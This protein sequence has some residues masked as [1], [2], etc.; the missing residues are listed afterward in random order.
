MK[1]KTRG[2]DYLSP[3]AKRTLIARIEE[4]EDELAAIDGK[5]NDDT[6]VMLTPGQ[7]GEVNRGAIE[8]SLQR[9]KRALATLDPSNHR[10]SGKER[11]KSEAR[12]KELLESIQ[13][14]ML[15]AK[16]FYASPVSD[17]AMFNRAVQA[18]LKSEADPSFK[19]DVSEFRYLS[20]LLEPEDPEF[21]NIENYRP[22][23]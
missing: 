23:S 19:K 7:C 12:R 20:R 16:E 17:V 10:F 2:G 13:K 6:G 9:D 22:Q 15:T 14:R 21:A 3:S 11:E 4:K 5:K 8:A 18:F 1:K